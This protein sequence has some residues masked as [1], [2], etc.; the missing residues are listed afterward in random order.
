MENQIDK[1]LQK[2]FKCKF[3]TDKKKKKNLQLK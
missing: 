2:P 1:R 3:T